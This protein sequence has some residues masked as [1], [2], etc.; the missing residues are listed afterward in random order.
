MLEWNLAV[1][2]ASDPRSNAAVAGKVPQD[3]ALTRLTSI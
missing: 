1:F 2:T 3:G